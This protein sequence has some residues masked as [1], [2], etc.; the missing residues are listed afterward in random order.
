MKKKEGVK[1]GHNVTITFNTLMLSFVVMAFATFRAMSEFRRFPLMSISWIE[2][3][4][5]KASAIAAPPSGP[6]PFQ[7]R[8]H[9][10]NLTFSYTE[11]KYTLH[12]IRN[13]EKCLCGIRNKACVLI[14]ANHIMSLFVCRIYYKQQQSKWSLLILKEFDKEFNNGNKGPKS[15]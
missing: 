15:E 5:T 12:K 3:F 11:Y 7:A 14:L 2:L 8:L 4:V 1:W 10:F 9:F 6:N 13:I